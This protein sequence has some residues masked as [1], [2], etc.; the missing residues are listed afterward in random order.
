MIRSIVACAL[1]DAYRASGLNIDVRL[2]LMISHIGLTIIMLYSAPEDITCL[3]AGQRQEG[4][5]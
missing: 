4:I 1:G 3:Q 2:R 5:C